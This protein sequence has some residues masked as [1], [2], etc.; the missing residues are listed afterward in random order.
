MK[1]QP[2]IFKDKVSEI[3]W[4]KMTSFFENGGM[5][6]VFTLAFFGIACA[7]IA[8]YGQM[9]FM[10]KWFVFFDLPLYIFLGWALYKA[11]MIWRNYQKW[12]NKDNSDG[13][14]TNDDGRSR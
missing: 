11:Y 8:H 13:A 2:F 1:I 9:G 12:V 7:I 6:V 10:W 4:R 3:V 14:R 5:A